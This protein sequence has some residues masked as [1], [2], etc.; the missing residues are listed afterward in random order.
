MYGERLYT[1]YYYKKF[2]IKDTNPSWSK[3]VQ[4]KNL[5]KIKVGWNIGLSDYS[6]ISI[7]KFKLYKYF[8]FIRPINFPNIKYEKKNNKIIYHCNVSYKRATIAYQRKFISNIYKYKKKINFFLYFKLLKSSLI[9][10]SPFGWGEINFR[11]FESIISKTVLIKPNLDHLKTWPNFFIKNKSYIDFNWN[12]KN[13]NRKIDEIL[14][15]KKKLNYIANFAAKNY[16]KYTSG[17]NAAQLFYKH[18]KK[19]IK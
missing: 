13:F 7:I 4:I 3:P 17:K 8:N 10:I 5:K 12:F 18:L 11:D 9:S 15:N 6:M 16:I 19:I 14:A 1:D 2:C